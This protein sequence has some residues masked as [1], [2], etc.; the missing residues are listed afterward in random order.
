MSARM[1]SLI[2]NQIYRNSY[3]IKMFRVTLFYINVIQKHLYSLRLGEILSYLKKKKSHIKKPT[4]PQGYTCY[5]ASLYRQTFKTVSKCL[6]S[7][8]VT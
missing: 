7:S 1:P 3:R 6:K 2:L 8:P 5:S 4:C